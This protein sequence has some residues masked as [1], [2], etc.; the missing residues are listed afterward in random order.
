MKSLFILTLGALVWTTVCLTQNMSTARDAHIE[1]TS[2]TTRL[3]N[4]PKIMK[5][6][7]EDGMKRA[8][9]YINRK[10]AP[11]TPIHIYR[12]DVRSN[13]KTCAN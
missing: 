1:D 5:I 6:L 2:K 7:N 3:E 12:T 8:I 10:Y 9:I 13:W 4:D 11:A